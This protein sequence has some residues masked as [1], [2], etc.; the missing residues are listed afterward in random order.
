LPSHGIEKLSIV[1]AFFQA[2]SSSAPSI[3]IGASVNWQA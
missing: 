1:A 2:A 3:A